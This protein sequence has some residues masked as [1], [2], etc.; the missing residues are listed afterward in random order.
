M[1]PRKTSDIQ[2]AL[3]KKGFQLYPV[4]DHHS[5]YYFYYKGKKTT[6]YTYFS[7]G[8]AEY[9]KNLMGCIRKQLKFK[10]NSLFN[11]FI[12]CPLSM[13]QYIEMLIANDEL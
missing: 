4:K 2:R 13:E 3:S 8:S 6:I 1:K 5:F 12:D 7:H 10:D 9:D 11:D